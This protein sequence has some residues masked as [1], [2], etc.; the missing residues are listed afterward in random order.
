[1]S[2][3]NQ[4][5]RESISSELAAGAF[6]KAGFKIDSAICEIVD[7]AIEANAKNIIIRFEWTE[8]SYTKI[9]K[10]VEKFIFIDDGEGMNDRIIYDYFIAAESTKKNNT[11]GIGKFGLGAY[12]SC[13]SQAKCGEV[14]S[15]TEGGKWM[16]T[17]LR[18]GKKIP[19]PVLREP[20]E[21]YRRY[22]H[23]TIVI[24][25][26][27]TN[28][29]FKDKDIVDKE[30]NHQDNDQE[31][32]EDTVDYEP[33]L[34]DELGRIYR[35]FIGD[36]KS[37]PANDGSKTINNENKIKIILE[38][39]DED[40]IDVMPY[41]PLFISYDQNNDKPKI[42]S[43]RVKLDTGDQVGWMVITYSYYPDNWLYGYRPGL[44]HEN[45]IIR[46]ITERNQGISLVREGRELY[47]GN[48][49]GGP[50]KILNA[51]QS[52]SNNQHF[53]KVDRWTGIEIEFTRESDDIFGVEF[54]KTRIRME[55]FAR[56]KISEAI[57][58]TIIKRRNYFKEI[59]D[60]EKAKIGETKSQGSGGTSRIQP[61]ISTSKH[62]DATKKRL[63][64]FAERYKDASEKTEDVFNDLLK[65]FHISLSHDLDSKGPLISYESEA[66]SVLVKY[67][68][69][70][71]F[72]RDFFEILEKMENTEQE[73]NMLKIREHFDILLASYGFAIKSIHDTTKQ[74]DIQTTI[75]YLISNWG[76]SA[77]RLSNMKPD[78]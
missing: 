28:P 7:N 19:R 36:K 38:L 15:K 58:P 74:Q 56:R 60:K 31:E 29:S 8:K 78:E 2:Q 41:D 76:V 61:T 17:I 32:E 66:D 30:K 39:E 5:S 55:R 48:W 25:S 67:N 65:G 44:S 50:I 34:I 72:I 69:A 18:F 68:M 21:E 3:Y 27:I 10:R 42:I 20:P 24:W 37:V 4:E 26:D 73:D 46:K 59:R 70:H 75:D 77:R 23:G 35:K 11:S 14:Y 45:R 1:M 47:F 57:S 54:N 71:S 49:P 62:D 51:N 53:D 63:R 16:Y 9:R 13:I 64:E 33:K 6:A 52:P 40:P 43:Q 22:D 12:M